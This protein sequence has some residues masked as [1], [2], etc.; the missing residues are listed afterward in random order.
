MTTEVSQ[1]RLG[2]VTTNV[3]ANMI[4]RAPALLSLFFVPVFI[5]YLGVEAYGLIGVYYAISSLLYLLDFGLGTATAREVARLDSTDRAGVRPYVRAVEVVYLA[6]GGLVA[7]LSVAAAPWIAHHWLNAPTLPPAVIARAVMMI[8]LSVAAYWP[9]I[10]YLSAF[11]GLQRQMTPNLI[12]AVSGVLRPF[13]LLGVLHF[14]SSSIDTFFTVQL[15]ITL[16]MSLAGRVLFWRAVPPSYGERKGKLFGPI[17]SV[18]RFAGHAS[19]SS[20]LTLCLA[21]VDKVT[22]SR[23]AP[24][25]A[26]GYYTVAAGAASIIILAVQPFF[27][28]SYPRFVE[29]ISLGKEQ[30]LRSHYRLFSQAVGVIAVPAGIA[31]AVFA[32]DVMASYVRDP[33]VAV[34]T[35]L[36]FRLGA[37]SAAAGALLVVSNALQMA[38]GRLRILLMQNSVLLVLSAASSVAA[39]RSHGAAGAAAVLLGTSLLALACQIPVSHFVLLRGETGAWLSFAIALPAAASGA[40]IAVGYAAMSG[41]HGTD[42]RTACAVV[43][44]MVALGAAAFAA[45]EVRAWIALRTSAARKAVLR[46]TR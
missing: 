12:M 13:L 36:L 35:E 17:R 16:A 6:T 37:L 23:F 1:P 28:A 41:V 9:F 15:L 7:V 44:G 14:V 2:R 29:L 33:H 26:L 24:L 31:G 20:V 22:I 30:A 3:I 42:L 45:P 40:V 10:M 21:N 32:S 34:R 18:L 8:G 39:V 38:F 43:T 46:R 4:G 25:D 11:L 5:R 27:A 19:V